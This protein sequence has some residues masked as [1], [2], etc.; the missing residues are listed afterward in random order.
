MPGTSA[1]ST[2]RDDFRLTS[3]AAWD[4]AR[5]SGVCPRT[6]RTFDGSATRPGPVLSMIEHP[7]SGMRVSR[8]AA[9]TVVPE[10]AL[11]SEPLTE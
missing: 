5:T 6:M 4:T 10:A 3:S 7:I 1:A 11:R 2:S 8:V 9:T